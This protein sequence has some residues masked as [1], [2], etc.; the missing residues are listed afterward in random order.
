MLVT[1]IAFNAASQVNTFFGVAPG[2]PIT[3]R[4]I[5]IQ[6]NFV[7]DQNIALLQ[8]DVMIGDNLSITIQPEVNM[9]F[10]YSY[11]HG[12]NTLWKEIKVM[13][14]A[15]LY[16]RGSILEDALTAVQLL[17]SST[18]HAGG[19]IFN[20]NRYGITHYGTNPNFVSLNSITH[21]GFGSN[22]LTGVWN[23]QNTWPFYTIPPGSNFSIN[24]AFSNAPVQ[25][26]PPLNN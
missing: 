7:V 22:V 4:Y 11:A 9:F 2:T 13:P 17:D 19:C 21:C 12:C 1:P 8:S 6:G 24:N 18:F 15:S 25:L 23:N 14:G 3:Q 10:Y 5:V 26:L 20:K 16:M